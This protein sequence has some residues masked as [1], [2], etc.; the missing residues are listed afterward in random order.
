MNIYF[1]DKIITVII[2]YPLNIIIYLF[3]QIFRFVTKLVFIRLHVR[4][5]WIKQINGGEK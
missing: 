3:S 5:I 2:M 4:R 1:V